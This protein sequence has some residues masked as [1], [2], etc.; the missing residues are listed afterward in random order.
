MWAGNNRYPLFAKPKTIEGQVH[1]YTLFE[2]TASTGPPVA[3]PRLLSIG[4]GAIASDRSELSVPFLETLRIAPKE[5]PWRN[6]MNSLRGI[7]Q[8]RL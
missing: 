7:Q 5:T 4:G 8:M 6:G 3:W 1:L 2:T